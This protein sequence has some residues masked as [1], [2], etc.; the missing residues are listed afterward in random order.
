MTS[1]AVTTL[2][3]RAYWESYWN[4]IHH[5]VPEEISIADNKYNT[6]LYSVFKR[7]LDPS[8]E[9]SVVEIGGAPGL[10][11]T[12]L[13]KIHD[14]LKLG[15]IDYSDKGV[16]ETEALMSKLNVDIAIHQKDVYKS[17]LS[18]LPEYDVVYSLG[19]VEHYEDLAQSLESHLACIKDGG[20]VII[21]V[22]VFLGINEWLVD[23]LAPENKSTW[24]P[25]IMDDRSW[26]ELYK[27]KDIEV[28]ADEYVGGF[29]PH[30]HHR[31]ED[32]NSL[33]KKIIYVLLHKY[34]A[35]IW[36]RIPGTEK[37][38]SRYFSFFYYFVAQK[39]GDVS[40]SN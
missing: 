6:G 29:D 4:E 39:R 35:K 21:G 5:E 40:T 20:L 25:S 9:L 31:L 18:D 36:D 32:K 14:Q 3:E 33:Y 13:T 38:N 17:D 16:A 26:K 34:F 2:T 19:V 24:Y 12:T 1:K 11:L 27:R 23:R 22:P 8:K 30:V 15:I 28:L 37:L 10:F 7:F